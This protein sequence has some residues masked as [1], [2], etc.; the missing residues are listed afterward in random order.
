MSMFTIEIEMAMFIGI[1][2][3]SLQPPSSPTLKQ[4]I[5]TI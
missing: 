3:C 5:L 4:H 2:T 1:Y